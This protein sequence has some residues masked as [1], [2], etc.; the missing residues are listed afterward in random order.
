MHFPSQASHKE[1][2]SKDIS[3]LQPPLATNYRARGAW[4]ETCKTVTVYTHSREAE[5]KGRSP[6]PANRK[7]GFS[8]SKRGDRYRVMH[9]PTA[10][11]DGWSTTKDVLLR[12]SSES[13][14]T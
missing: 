9:T 3:I 4:T 10:P 12:E 7:R 8:P 14:L 11:G 13:D 2:G 5:K 6:L 1:F